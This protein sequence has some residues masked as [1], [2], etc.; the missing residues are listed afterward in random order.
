PAAAQRDEPQWPPRSPRDALLLTPRGREKY[1]AM[2]AEQ[3]RYLQMSPSSPSP[4]RRT[5]IAHSPE[6]TDADLDLDLDDDDDDDDGDDD[7]DDEE[8]LQLKLQ[9]I[10]ARLKIKRLQKQREKLQKQSS[11]PANPSSTTPVGASAHPRSQPQSQS[12]SQPHPQSLPRS[13]IKPPRPRSSV[14]LEFGD[15]PKS[16]A[17]VGKSPARLAYARSPANQLPNPMTQKPYIPPP[18]SSGLTTGP[19]RAERD[20]AQSVAQEYRDYEVEVPVSPVQ[21]VHRAIDATSPLRQILSKGLR[22]EDISLG[23]HARSRTA[24]S[25]ASMTSAGSGSGSG[26][27][28]TARSGQF[29]TAAAG[30]PLS[31]N[32][33][34]ALAKAEEAEKKK[35]QERIQNIR[36]TTF[37]ISQA[38][39]DQYKATAV[40]VSSEPAAGPR[41]YSRE[42]I[43]GS[44]PIEDSPKSEASF[45]PYSSFHLKKRILPHSVVARHM[46]DAK[47]FSLSDLVRSVKAPDFELPDIEQSIVTFAILA[48]KSEPREHKQNANF[49][50]TQ[51]TKYMIMTLTDLNHDVELF[52]FYSGFSRFWKLTEGTVIAI[53]NP[54]VMPPPAGRTDTGRWSFVINS[55]ADTILE[56]GTARD[57]GYCKAVKKD[58]DT[59]SAWVNAKR[60]EYC[61]YHSNA[62]LQRIKQGRVEM[63]GSGFGRG[64]R[65]WNGMGAVNNKKYGGSSFRAAGSTV[66]RGTGPSRAGSSQELSR[67]KG[68]SDFDAQAKFFLSRTVSAADMLDGK[69]MS[70]AE[71]QQRDENIRRAIQQKEKER[72]L[73]RQLGGM[74]NASVG[75]EY[76]AQIAAR[77]SSSLSSSA[78]AAVGSGS[79]SSSSHMKR[80]KEVTP[81]PVSGSGSRSGS[82]HDIIGRGCTAADI[83][84]YAG[85]R[86]RADSAM[87]ASHAAASIGSS[88]LGWGK[89]LK[90]KLDRMKGGEK[91]A[92]SQSAVTPEKEKEE[93]KEEGEDEGKDGGGSEMAGK[94][95]SGDRDRSPVRKKTRFVTDRGIKE[96]GHES[97]AAIVLDEE[98]DEEVDTE[99]ETE[100]E[101][102][103]HGGFSSGSKTEF[104]GSKTEFA[105]RKTEVAARQVQS[106]CAQRRATSPAPGL[107]RPTNTASPSVA[108]RP[109]RRKYWWED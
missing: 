1:R 2:T 57:L 88:S 4:L 30:R 97:L 39:M 73:A 23:K 15:L 63:T 51:D 47:V 78:A 98:Q 61:E 38:E 101:E 3:Q 21:R 65:D 34:L 82:L 37:D 54:S 60:T 64:G 26:Y 45:E 52:L 18:A 70:M 81:E 84:L 72:E 90:D 43:L 86:K 36:E 100:R 106:A 20:R 53:L 104:A 76:M 29:K 33:R 102:S 8:T 12:Q 42:E 41:H 50:K 91:L 96:A 6:P 28:R 24:D 62:S 11:S 9:A 71:K 89:G 44:K 46:G 16:P 40:E 77:S 105:T 31:F 17:T 14:S 27:L 66:I 13:E 83:D 22:A 58:G 92:D 56:I 55:D 67:G 25:D 103:H 93:E 5:R 94:D 107:S 85:K 19:S 75:R 48:K 32:E 74:G 109:G 68:H 59:C 87:S 108:H 99:A 10:K 80:K 69:H 49:K 35:H 95:E 7:D 79:D